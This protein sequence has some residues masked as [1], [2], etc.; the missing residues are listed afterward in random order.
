[1]RTAQVALPRL[2]GMGA[3][4]GLGWEIISADAPV[5]IGHDGGTI[6]QAA[7]LRVVPEAGLAVALLTNGGDVFGLFED[8]IAQ[9]LREVAD[10][11]LPSMP[12]P[13]AEPAAVEPEPLL[14]LYADTIYD[15]VVSVDDEGRIWLDRT[16][17]DIIAEIGEKPVRTELVG[18]G[19]D[20]LI[21]VEATRGIHPV[22]AFLGDAGNGKRK[23]IHYG[24]VV[25]RAD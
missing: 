24:R 20:S 25:T 23:Y 6:G 11:T 7:F 3:A 8:V 5:V 22:Y 1:M 14:G 15:L 16:P 21:A 4:W 17:K 9:I 10:V 2:T 18:Y 13:H 12:V 19:S